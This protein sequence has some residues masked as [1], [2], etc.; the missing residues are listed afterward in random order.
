MLHEL[1]T[2]NSRESRQINNLNVNIFQTGGATDRAALNQLVSETDLL[3]R[4]AHGEDQSNNVLCST[5]LS[6][7]EVQDFALHAQSKLDIKEQFKM[8]VEAT[9]E[10]V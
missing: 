8:A 2:S 10:A 1:K 4:L 9:V 5:L 6:A 7:V 3:A